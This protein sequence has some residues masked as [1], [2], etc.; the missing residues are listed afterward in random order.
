MSYHHLL[1]AGKI[2]SMELKNRIVLAAMGTEY[3]EKD[4]TCSERLWDYYEA[5]AKGGTGLLI[6]ET[7]AAM[8]PAGMSMPRMV[9]FSEDRFLPGLTELTKRAHR[10][11]AK[12]VAQLNHSGKVSSND[13]ANG[14][15]I[16]V[17]SIPKAKQSDMG[18]SLTR[19]EIAT[20]VRGAGPDGK[21]PRYHPLEK[22]DIAALTEGFVQAARR[23]KQSNFDGVEIH[24][25]HGYVF[26][27][28][29][30]PY[31]NKRDDEYGGSLEN[32]ARLLLDVV[33]AVRAEVGPDFALLVRIDAKEFRIDEGIQPD[34]AVETAKMIEAAGADAIDV[35]AYADTSIGVAFTEAP[36]PHEP[37]LY[38]PFAK[39]VK[40]VVNI[41]V[42]AVGRVEPADADAAIGAGDYDFL[43]MGRKLLAD[44][45][46]PNKLAAGKE[47]S[48]RP[49]IYCYVCV[50]KI[51]LNEAVCCAAN[52]GTG[53]E[54]ELDNLTL[55]EKPR[56]IG[57]IGGGPAGMEA[58]RV[59]ATRGHRVT[60]WEREKDL[61]GTARIAA[62]P[63][64]P[65]GQLVKW[66]NHAVRELPIDL[67]LG[68]V[69][70][71]DAILAEKMD[72]V[73]VATGALRKA[74]DMPGNE[75]DHVFD[76]DRLRGVLFGGDADATRGLAAYKRAMLTSAQMTGIL[77]NIDWL[78]A[79]S[80]VW[81]PLGKRIVIIG[82]GLVGLELAEYLGERGRQVTVVEPGPNLGAELSVVRRWRVLDNLKH[83][84]VAIVRQAS[85]REITAEGVHY[86]QDGSRHMVQ[87]DQ[88]I[89]A[90]GA[91]TDTRLA[92]N[93]NGRGIA[94]S[95]AGDCMEVG[96]IE[97]AMLSARRAAVAL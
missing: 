39:A 9:G 79:L 32:R 90:M 63:Y 30:S 72:H 51:F 94:T 81:M 41:P 2:G 1:S 35:S 40:K 76:S 33:R 82:G 80:K 52:P 77:R 18:A 10:H 48:I 17:P 95:V 23:A 20:F 97:G 83:D 92:D 55:V 34:L 43:C 16:W 44:P 29:L 85:I 25:G 11:G 70:T 56:R 6:L 13:V 62:L 38:I 24:G 91:Q 69:A 22:Q 68:S 60:L 64:E 50:G 8:W 78:R 45:E 47:K 7:S 96:Y 74:P 28:F 36:I 27:S 89:I 61:G 71:P 49:C 5:R 15:P 57:V 75:L 58:A 93:L 31:Y 88:V 42:L 53:R 19:E 21:G 87:A 59:L 84:D 73:I 4:G 54:A 86:E 65:N 67:R 12:I 3:C 14:R 26:S 46:L 66:L 37:G